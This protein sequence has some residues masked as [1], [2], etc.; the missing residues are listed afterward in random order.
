MSGALRAPSPCGGGPSTSPSSPGPTAG[1][2]VPGP[3]RPD[4]RSV[5]A[6][7]TH[8]RGRP[9]PRPPTRGPV[10]TVTDRPPTSTTKRPGRGGHCVGHRSALPP[11]PP[12]A[13]L[14]RRTPSTSSR[15]GGRPGS[16]ATGRHGPGGSS[17]GPEGSGGTGGGRVLT[18]FPGRVSHPTPPSG[19]GT[20]R[21]RVIG[22]PS[23]TPPS[24][25]ASS[26]VS[27]SPVRV[28]RGVSPTEP[29]GRPTRRRPTGLTVSTY[30]RPGRPVT[31]HP[32]RRRLWGPETAGQGHRGPVTPNSVPRSPSRP[33][34]SRPGVSRRSSKT[35]P[36][37]SCPSSPRVLSTAPTRVR[38]TSSLGLSSRPF[39]P[40]AT[41]RATP[42]SPRPDWSGAFH[43]PTGTTG[44]HR[45]TPRPTP[46]TCSSPSTQ[47]P[48]AGPAPLPRQTRGRPV[49]STRP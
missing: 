12:R 10:G 41:V 44:P 48:R 16:R 2:G 23:P 38:V 25:T 13:V 45:D 7:S 3:R 15:P 32:R 35:T 40:P 42:D 47:S 5:T 43:A 14:T 4:G 24:T 22:G 46:T 1:A 11:S 29:R 30:P 19:D 31:G 9:S 39:P 34:D 37:P 18:F 17:G 33:S 36:S 20:R 26:G 6:S 49:R 21:D 28:D 27:A 8:L